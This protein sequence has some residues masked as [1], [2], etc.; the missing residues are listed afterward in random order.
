MTREGG[1]PEDFGTGRGL[2]QSQ[3]MRGLEQDFFL[4]VDSGALAEGLTNKKT[5]Q[6]GEKEQMRDVSSEFF[7]SEAVADKK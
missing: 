1:K 3:Q 7:L 4:S 2:L 5:S 6:T